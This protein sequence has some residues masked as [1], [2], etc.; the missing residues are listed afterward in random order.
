MKWQY[1]AVYIS[2]DE[3]TS[4]WVA[5]MVDGKV[6]HGHLDDILNHVGNDD[7]EMVS[8]QSEFWFGPI[9]SNSR[10]TVYRAFFKKPK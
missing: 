5:T 10:V 9:N 4:S 2:W 7:W 6:V 1:L 8:T 3:S